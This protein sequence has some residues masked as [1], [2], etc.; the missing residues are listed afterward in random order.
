MIYLYLV[1]GGSIGTL[2]RFGI[3]R[4]MLERF[5][6]DFPW[7]TLTVNLAGSF[8]LGLFLSTMDRAEVSPEVR[9]LWTVGFCGAFTTFSTFSLETV[10]LMQAGA[11]GRAAAYALGSV[12]LGLAAVW[13]GFEA[14]GVLARG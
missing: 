11:W 3:S 13:I 9:L 1:L 2:A 12:A 14:G 7:G 4:W 8:L 6:P 10:G 5:G